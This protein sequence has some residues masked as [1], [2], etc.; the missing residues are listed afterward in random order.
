MDE[1]TRKVVEVRPLGCAIVVYPE[2]KELP[3]KGRFELH[4]GR[5]GCAGR[6]EDGRYVPC[7]SERAPYCERC[8]PFNPCA[9]CTG[10]CLK[11][12][13]DCTY[14]HSI[15]FALFSPHLIKVG[16]SRTE[17]LEKR[18]REQ[19]ADM[20]VEVA[21]CE[22]GQV[23]RAIEHRL[24]SLVGDR[25]STASKMKGLA[26]PLD[27][28]GW[29]GLLAR[30]KPMGTPVRL[31]YFD[32]P[33]TTE[34]QP[35]SVEEHSTIAGNGL[36]CKGNLFVFEHM[37]MVRVIDMRDLLGF[38]LVSEPQRTAVQT[39]LGY[40]EGCGEDERIRDATSPNP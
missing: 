39:G 2:L 7:T 11:P 36:G 20:G 29:D 8:R 37:G 26:K 27:T 21:R 9:A 31:H 28:K 13:M 14:P 3:L 40:F 16:V 1:S 19:G 22:N 6:F 33:L 30:T 23:A 10:V 15:Y 32:E 35:W 5:R 38:E 18:W 4:L 17:R 24:K 12:E 34:P 25:V